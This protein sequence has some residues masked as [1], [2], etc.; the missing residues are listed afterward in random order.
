MTQKN[1]SWFLKIQGVWLLFL[2]CS[3][4]LIV[5]TDSRSIEPRLDESLLE[6][7]EYST[8]SASVVINI[9]VTLEDQQTWDDDFEF[10][11]NTY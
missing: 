11:E 10:A 3:F 6:Y 4:T 9:N 5:H 7:S 1:I 8:V 2:V